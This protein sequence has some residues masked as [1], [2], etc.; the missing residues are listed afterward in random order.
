[1]GM[2]AVIREEG[3]K[4]GIREGR[5]SGIK[6]GIKVSAAYMLKDG[7]TPNDVSRILKMPEEEVEKIKVTYIL[8]SHM[9]KD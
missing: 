4:S 7:M 6:E 2:A 1:M 5:E 3:R 8:E 9:N